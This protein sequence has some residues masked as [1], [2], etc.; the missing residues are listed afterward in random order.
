[1]VART[2]TQAVEQQIRALAEREREALRDRIEA[3]TAELATDS[4]DHHL[5]YRAL[6]LSAGDSHDVE[7]NQNIGRFLWSRAG[8]LIQEAVQLCFR[9]RFPGADKHRLPYQD[10]TRQRFYEIDLLVGSDAYEIKWRD[11]TTDGDHVN[12]EE[13]RIRRCV[14]EGLRPVGLTFFLPTRKQARRIQTRLSTIYQ[15]LGGVHHVEQAAW[16]HVEEQTGIDLRAI[17]ERIAVEATPEA[18]P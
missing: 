2:T 3:R 16:Q 12:K 4:R 14:A 7:L 9:A 15:E 11:A 18:G 1:M 8:K 5:I 6:G 17:I 13:A 10:G